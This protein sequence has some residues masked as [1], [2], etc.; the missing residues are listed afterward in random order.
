MAWPTPGTAA[1]G[2]WFRAACELAVGAS[3]AAILLH[4]WLIAGLMLPIVAASG[5]MAPAVLGPHRLVKCDRCDATIPIGLDQSSARSYFP[6]PNCRNGRLSLA[7]GTDRPGDR[8]LIN[9][10]AYFFRQPRRWEIVVARAPTDASHWSLKRIVGRPGEALQIR[11]GDVY[12]DGRIARKDLRQQLVLARL[13][14]RHRA[15][16]DDSRWRPDSETSRWQAGASGDGSFEIADSEVSTADDSPDDSP[17][18]WLRY[19][20]PDGQPVRDEESYSEGASRMLNDVPDVMI[21]ARIR[22]HGQGQLWLAGHDGYHEYLAAVDPQA[23]TVALYQGEQ[24]LAESGGS[25]RWTDRERTIVFSLFDRQILVAANDRVLLRHL[26][27]V[28]SHRPQPTARPLAIGTV[29]LAVSLREVA[30]WRDIYYT[31]PRGRST[32]GI[33][34][35]SRLATEQWFVLGDHSAVSKDSRTWPAGGALHSKLLLGKPLGVE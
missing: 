15:G 19:H 9:R 6:C 29:G 31:S 18:D 2:R 34:S 17:V 26:L 22:L 16:G 24:L 21:T 27:A 35:P 3:V 11:D 12:I 33:A 14:H 4:T 25:G 20:H 28:P 23:G 1:R 7:S 30:V 8:L 13:V 5:S 10:A 32:S